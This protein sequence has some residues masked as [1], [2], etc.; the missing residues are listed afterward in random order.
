MST[1]QTLTSLAMLKVDLDQ[2]HRNYV[3]YVSPFV[4]DIL[5]VEP[6]DVISDIRIAD[7]LL[8]RFGLKVPTKAAQHVLRRL[9]RKGYLINENSVFTVTSLLPASTLTAVQAE[10][11][12]HIQRVV[13]AITL[14][15]TRSGL[16]WTEDDTTKAITAFLGKFTVDC[17]RTYVF[18]TALPNIPESKSG[19]LYIVGRFI[20]DARLRND[21]AFDSFIVLVKGQMYSS[22]LLCPDL[23]SLEKKFQGVTFF[24]DTPL[25]LNLLGLHGQDAKR[26]ADELV[27]LLKKLR[28]TPAT[29]THTVIET[30]QVLT[31]AA[32][33]FNNPRATGRVVEEAR[34]NR[35][36]L[37]DL[38]LASEAV[39]E[40][41]RTV[42]VRTVKTPEYKES[43]QIDET[44]FHSALD[45]EIYYKGESALRNDVNSI[46]SIY[47]LRHGKQPVRL[48]DCG[49]VFVTT[50]STLAR[51]AFHLG[52]D[53]NSSREVS[54]VITAYSLANIAWLK[55]PVDAPTLPL[56]ETMALCYAALEPPPELFRKYVQEMDKL[57]AAG[58][59]SERDHEILRLAP[60]ARDELM[61]LTLGD[62][63]ALTVSSVKQILDN[64]KALIIADQRERHTVE[65]RTVTEESAGKLER[66]E[67]RERELLGKLATAEEALKAMEA[68]AAQRKSRYESIARSI[69][70][71]L[72]LGAVGLLTLGALAGAGLVSANPGTRLEIRGGLFLLTAIAVGW[73]VYSWYTGAAVRTFE[74][75]FEQW[76]TRKLRCWVEANRTGT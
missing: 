3:D 35:L 1:T 48:E 40:R 56:R 23:E 12:S 74:K 63:H 32:A 54:S 18:N 20:R 37:S 5:H 33:N 8:T 15:A 24:F 52:K 47:V 30:Q 7:K 17:L 41:L 64:V 46:R 34:R 69:A 65:L 61:E 58:Q 31:G 68:K 72:M 38:L 11:S 62:E 2:Q 70:R 43:F 29:F 44:A 53:H 22:A 25:L 26:A 57:L 49:A 59:I 27:T 76:L 67:R 66:H 71:V 28:G 75:R 50:N 6:P 14:E 9:H 39:D 19:D 73:G 13:E 51:T 21:P 36:E 42:G 16:H 10:A 55:S 45:E 4:I 60:S